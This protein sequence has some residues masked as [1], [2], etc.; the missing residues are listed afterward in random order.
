[1]DVGAELERAR[2]AHRDRRWMEAVEAFAGIDAAGRLDVEDLEC[3]A[4]ALD[5]VGRGDDAIAVLQRVYAARVDAG[6]IGAALRGAFWLYRAQAFNAEFA[7]AGG[8]IARAARLAEGRADC[9]QQG[10]LLLPE[11]ERLLRDG[12][13][14]AAFATA[15][16]A[17][18]LGA[19]CGD[20]DL[21]TIAAH[22]QGRA[23]VGDGRV[24]DGLALLDEAMSYISAGETSGRSPPGSIAR[25]SRP[26]T[27]CMTCAAA[28]GPRRSTRG[29]TPFRSSPAPT[30]G[31]AAFTGPSCCS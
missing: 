8:W 13:N 5:L 7:H 16:R 29:A 27:R 18:A 3:L 20:R 14:P 15:G 4:E 23:V 26:V 12:D 9:A 31:S 22:L 25:R 24:D 2:R 30:P 19:G 17:A 28:S 1:M 21:I 6:D 10:Y 11:A